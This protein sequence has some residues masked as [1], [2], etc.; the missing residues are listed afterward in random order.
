MTRAEAENYIYESYLKAEK[1][2]DYSMPDSKKTSGV[3]K[4]DFR[5]S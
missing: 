5:K 4:T 2:W 3:F 1:E